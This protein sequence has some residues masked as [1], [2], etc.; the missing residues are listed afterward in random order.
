MIPRR[1]RENFVA[2][3]MHKAK[4][5][6][7]P[8]SVARIAAELM[9]LATEEQR[10]MEA[11]CSVD[12]DDATHNKNVAKSARRDGRVAELAGD[13]GLSMETQGDPRGVAYTVGGIPVPAEG[14]TG[15]QIEHLCRYW[16]WRRALTKAKE[17]AT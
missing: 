17:G 3:L 14:Y 13:L 5:G 16:E 4:P 8:D 1:E 12:F 7:H 2:W 15:D 11:Y 10:W 9:R 6:S